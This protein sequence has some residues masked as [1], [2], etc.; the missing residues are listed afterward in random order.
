M[1]YCP[2]G[3]KESDMNEVTEHYFYIIFKGY[4]PFTVIFKIGY[5]SHIVQYILESYINHC[6][7]LYIWGCFVILQRLTGVRG[8]F[9]CGHEGFLQN[10][11]HY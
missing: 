5:I 6:L 2:Q 3:H 7:S 4:F 9:L 8:V 11:S 10:L 1:G